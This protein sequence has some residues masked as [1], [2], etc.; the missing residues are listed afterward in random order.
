MLTPVSA[1]PSGVCVLSC[2]SRV[3]LSASLFTAA[4]QAPLS[5]G[6]L[7]AR[8]RGW[9][10]IPFSQESSWPRDWTQVACIPGRFFTFQVTREAT[11]EPSGVTVYFGNHGDVWLVSSFKREPA[12]GS[13]VSGQPPAAASLG[14]PQ[15][16]HHG[17][18]FWVLGISCQHKTS[19]GTLCPAFS[20][21]LPLPL[22]QVSQASWSG[23]FFCHLLTLPSI[24]QRHD[25]E[26]ISY[27]WLCLDIWFPE[28][29]TNS[30]VYFPLLCKLMMNKTRHISR[31]VL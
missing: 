7:Q 31:S 28:D 3:Q 5:M 6:I 25:S 9:V 30:D 13:S 26:H 12:L 29:Q 22:S 1:E 4:R 23:S 10:A 11:K 16:S 18:A 21:F 19:W 8:I 24:F 2:F 27:S 17:H 20:I 15:L 14:C